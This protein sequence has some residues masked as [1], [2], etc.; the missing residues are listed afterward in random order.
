MLWKAQSI[1]CLSNIYPD[2]FPSQKWN[3]KITFP[4]LFSII[5]CLTQYH[6]QGHLVTLFFCI[7]TSISSG[8]FW[9]QIIAFHSQTLKKIFSGTCSRLFSFVFYLT[10]SNHLRPEIRFFF[11]SFLSKANF[12][13][14]TQRQKL[15]LFTQRAIVVEPAINPLRE[16]NS[17][18]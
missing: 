17:K 8:G 5:C 1:K 3:E 13:R 11:L 15:P 14:Q 18:N 16:K 7:G 9:V 2:I 10:P 6:Q 4:L 12:P